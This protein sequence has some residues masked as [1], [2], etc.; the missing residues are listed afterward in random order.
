MVNKAKKHKKKKKQSKLW[1]KQKTI[2]VLYRWSMNW[3]LIDT[4]LTNHIF[5]P[6]MPCSTM[7]TNQWKSENT[8]ST[9]S[10]NTGLSPVWHIR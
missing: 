8:E 1:I 3:L 6:E 7:A 2:N 9:S 5:N 4:V 10:S